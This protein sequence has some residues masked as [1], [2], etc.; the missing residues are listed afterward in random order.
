MRQSR[1]RKD[2]NTDGKHRTIAEEELINKTNITPEDVI[3]LPSIT[4][5]LF[6]F[7]F[8]SYNRSK[9]ILTHKTISQ[10][11]SINYSYIKCKLYPETKH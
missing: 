8:I 2:V 5:R 9:N 11:V 10:N 6:C 4:K 7:V 1:T 3:L